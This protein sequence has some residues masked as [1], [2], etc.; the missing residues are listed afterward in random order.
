MGGLS[1]TFFATIS[2]SVCHY[3]LSATNQ[4]ISKKVSTIGLIDRFLIPR[5]SP[6][7]YLTEKP[8]QPIDYIETFRHSDEL[9]RS[10]RQNLA[11]KYYGLPIL[12]W[13]NYFIFA[14]TNF[15][16][17]RLDLFDGRL[18]SNDLHLYF[19]NDFRDDPQTLT[20][21]LLTFWFTGEHRWS[22]LKC[23]VAKYNLHFRPN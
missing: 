10:I 16:L 12:K 15:S 7:F 19:L 20:F 4:A 8:T 11:L 17:K 1:G 5:Y 2:N 13:P 3:Y 23:M 14:S 22:V 6:K 21:Q 18:Y 9:L